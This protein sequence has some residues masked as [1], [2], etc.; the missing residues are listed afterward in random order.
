MDHDT[1]SSAG[2]GTALLM[3]V[4]LSGCSSSPTIRTDCERRETFYLK[5]VIENGAPTRVVDRDTGADATSLK[6][7]RDDKVQWRAQKKFWIWFYDNN[8]PSNQTMFESGWR[9]TIG[10]PIR[11]DAPNGD[12][13]YGVA[14]DCQTGTCKQLD[15]MI[16]VRD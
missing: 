13:S 4:L 10:A 11:P 1:M 12:Y 9:N 2:I 6:V 14:T 16:I 5:V 7:C 8:S 3:L 15:P